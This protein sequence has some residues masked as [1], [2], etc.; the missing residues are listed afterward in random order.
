MR[1]GRGGTRAHVKYVC[2][3]LNDEIYTEFPGNATT[4]WRALAPS[5]TLF[6]LSVEK[7][8]QQRHRQSAFISLSSHA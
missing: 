5:P 3:W 4:D 1:E 2:V 7:H 8:A 6:D